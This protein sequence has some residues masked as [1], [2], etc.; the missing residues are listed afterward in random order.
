VLNARARSELKTAYHAD[1]PR[2]F[3][4]RPT[5]SAW[6]ANGRDRRPAVHDSAS[7]TALSYNHTFVRGLKHGPRRCVTVATARPSGH[8]HVTRG[9]AVDDND[10]SRALN[11]SVRS[12]QSTRVR[13]SVRQPEEFRAIHVVERIRGNGPVAPAPREPK[14]AAVRRVSSSRVSHAGNVD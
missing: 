10:F 14:R 11:K 13:P 9:D 4:V 3:N 2:Q 12:C 6:N 5:L 8:G 7:G 1:N